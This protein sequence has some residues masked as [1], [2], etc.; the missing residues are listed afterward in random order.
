MCAAMGH[1]D[2][3][4]ISGLCQGIPRHVFARELK[5]SRALVASVGSTIPSRWYVVPST[6][7]TSQSGHLVTSV[8][9]Y[10]LRPDTTPVLVL[11]YI[12]I[13]WVGTLGGGGLTT[14]H[15]HRASGR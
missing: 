10:S 6:R 13:L 5:V 4:V 3:T 9:A 2:G 8:L 7:T 12:T 1:T 15:R 11:R 14:H